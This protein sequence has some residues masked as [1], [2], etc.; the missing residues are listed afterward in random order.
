MKILIVSQD[1][2]LAALTGKILERKGYD[3][4]CCSDLSQ[5]AA[6]I[7]RE[8]IRLVIADL[9]SDETE[10]L[11]FCEVI[12]SINNPPKLL[13]ITGNG[14]EESSILNAGADDWIKKPYNTSVFLA[15]ISALLRQSGNDFKSENVEVF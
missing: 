12:K 15:R 3:V 8:K 9:E 1:I 11:K 6:L 10:A 13:F 2:E 5:T 7:E 4:S 14:E